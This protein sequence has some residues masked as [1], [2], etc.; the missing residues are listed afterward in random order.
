MSVQVEAI[1]TACLFMPDHRREL[2]RV[3]S[4]GPEARALKLEF[5]S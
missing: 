2:A 4:E 1:R 5:F 3:I